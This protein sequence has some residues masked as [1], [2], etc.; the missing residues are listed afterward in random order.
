MF[1]EDITPVALQ[2]S[3]SGYPS[4]SSLLWRFDFLNDN[5]GTRTQFL[6]GNL[7]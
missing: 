5:I 7:S 4:F 2:F 3:C 6:G 1:L